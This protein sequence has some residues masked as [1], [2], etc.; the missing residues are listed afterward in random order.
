MTNS[1]MAVTARLPA[2]GRHRGNRFWPTVI[3]DSAPQYK[4]MALVAV[5]PIAKIANTPVLTPRVS[6]DRP[7]RVSS[8]GNAAPTSTPSSIGNTEPSTQPA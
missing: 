5:M 6:V 2:A 8:V 1:T 3:V 7:S 4:F